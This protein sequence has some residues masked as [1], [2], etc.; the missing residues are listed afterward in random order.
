[1]ANNP[2]DRTQ[3]NTGSPQDKQNQQAGQQ[4]MGKDS[5]TERKAGQ[6]DTSTD[7]DMQGKTGSQPD[8]RSTDQNQKR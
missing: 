4:G 6:S 1:M 5:G 3:Q 8:A 2:N 7:R